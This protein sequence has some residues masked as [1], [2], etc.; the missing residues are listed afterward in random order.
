M[1]INDGSLAKQSYA[2]AFAWSDESTF[3]KRDTSNN[4]ILRCSFHKTAKRLSITGLTHLLRLRTKIQSSIVKALIIKIPN[5]KK[6][7]ISP[8]FCATLT[9]TNLSLLLTGL[10]YTTCD[11]AT[12]E[13]KKKEKYEVSKKNFKTNTELSKFTDNTRLSNDDKN[14]KITD[15][16]TSQKLISR[17]HPINLNNNITDISQKKDLPTSANDT[18]SIA[19]LRDIHNNERLK[20][21][22]HTLMLH[23]HNKATLH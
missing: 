13:T 19:Y 6:K 1:W 23:F 18:K 22:S 5:N 9:G 16:I 2:H 7:T 4:S 11:F 17:R 21:P 10:S 3:Q 8:N 20:L 15:W 14:T 12:T